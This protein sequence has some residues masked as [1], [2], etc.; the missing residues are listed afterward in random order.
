MF[1]VGQKKIITRGFHIK[2]NN[3]HNDRKQTVKFLRVYVD[4]DLNWKKH[5]STIYERISRFIGI[6]LKSRYFLSYKTLNF[7][8]HLYIPIYIMVISYGDLHM[9]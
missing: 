2:I 9:N 8:S 4:K 3:E 1:T 7:I 5:I 6:I